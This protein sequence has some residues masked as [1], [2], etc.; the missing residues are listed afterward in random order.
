LFWE[1][2][3]GPAS[4]ITGGFFFFKG[5]E[6]AGLN[7]LIPQGQ[8][9]A[10]FHDTEG[11]LGD[12]LTRLFNLPGKFGDQCFP[13]VQSAMWEIFHTLLMSRHVENEDYV[14]EDIDSAEKEETFSRQVEHYMRSHLSEKISLKSLANDLNVSTA[15]L[16]SKFRKEQKVSPM[17]RLNEIRIEAAKTHL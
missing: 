7:K 1:D 12:L 14:I 5:G 16:R 10:K 17:M 15:T 6:L 8:C 4:K 11:K 2:I 3:R 9:Y 13:A